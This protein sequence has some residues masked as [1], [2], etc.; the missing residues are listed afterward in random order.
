MGR[1]FITA[2]DH[3]SQM[4]DIGVEVNQ[5]ETMAASS[6]LTTLTDINQTVSKVF[7]SAPRA[8]QKPLELVLGSGVYFTLNGVFDFLIYCY[9]RWFDIV[10]IVNVT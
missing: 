4:E 2:G 5:T 6:L 1:K 7:F 3:P 8:S 10:K 9:G